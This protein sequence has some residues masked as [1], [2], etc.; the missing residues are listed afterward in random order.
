M[1]MADGSLASN[2]LS[3]P[4]QDAEGL[5]ARRPVEGRKVDAQ[6]RKQSLRLS[7][8]RATADVVRH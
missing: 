8:S 1:L 4:V 5:N 2:F 3:I 7:T 6:E